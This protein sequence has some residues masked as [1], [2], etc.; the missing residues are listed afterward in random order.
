[1]LFR[2]TKHLR[3]SAAGGSTAATAVAAAAAAVVKCVARAR[4]VVV[5]DVLA[6]NALRC[7]VGCSLQADQ[8]SLICW[9]A[10]SIGLAKKQRPR[11][12]FASGNILQ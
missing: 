8:S 11:V 3:I 9:R 12:V 4:F 5:V 10:R 7:F 1:M 2:P 6:E